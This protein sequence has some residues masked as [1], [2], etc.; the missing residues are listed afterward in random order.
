MFLDASYQGGLYVSPNNF[1]FSGSAT[2]KRYGVNSNATVGTFGLTLPGSIA[3]T[4]A[5]GG[6]YM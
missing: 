6:Q 1:T 4:T 2:G 5:T 3:G